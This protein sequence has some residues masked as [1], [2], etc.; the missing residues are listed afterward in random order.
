MCTGFRVKASNLVVASG[1]AALER[2]VLRTAVCADQPHRSH[3]R[4][5]SPEL[6]AGVYFGLALAGSLAV[7]SGNFL[8]SS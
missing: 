7:T 8:M 2:S 3:A 6:I 4:S 1:F 5:S